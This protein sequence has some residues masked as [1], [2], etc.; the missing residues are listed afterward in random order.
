[1][2]AERTRESTCQRRTPAQDTRPTTSP[3]SAKGV[4]MMMPKR[5]RWEGPTYS[6]A[7]LNTH[8]KVPTWPRPERNREMTSA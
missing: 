7:R 1:L 5:V 8:M 6:S 4:S 2:G 3:P